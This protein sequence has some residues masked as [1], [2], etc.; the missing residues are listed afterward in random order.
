MHIHIL[1]ICGT[2]MGGLAV[3]AKQAGHKVTGC[4]AN[5]YPPMSTQLEAQG[6]QLIQG[7]GAEQTAL[8]PDLFVIGNVVSRGNPLME[9]ILNRGLPYTS[10]PQWI[11][12]HILADKWVLAVAGTHGKTTTSAMLA[13]I[14]ED[15]G[16]NPGFLIGGV[17]MNFGISAR[18]SGNG[19]ETSASP[20]FVIEADEYDTAFFD[21]RSKFVHYHAKTAILN[22]LE[23]DHADIFPDLAAIET[24][25]HH[26]VRTVPGIGRLVVN[27]REPALQRV[28]T[29]GCWSE[30]ELFGIDSQAAQH[31]PTQLGWSLTTHTDGNFDVIFNGDHQGTVV[32]S[33]TGEHNRMNAIAAIAAA[34][35]VGVP[36]VQAIKAL[37]RFENVKR[38][39]ELR[40][41]VNQIAVYD[42][43]AHHPTA[44]TT[45]IAG[46]RKKIG[47]ARILAVLE[48]RSNT[49]KLGAM[50][51]TLPE[52][53]IDADLVF[54]YGAKG[55]GKEALGWDLGQALAP[56][57]NKAQAFD[58]L[59]R[60]IGA[61][62]QA[63]HPGDQIL[64]MSNGGFG[65]VH[66]K[67]LDA[68][69]NPGTHSLPESAPHSGNASA[70][71]SVIIPARS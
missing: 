66:Q 57:G 61:V 16:Y 34:R 27:A 26:L 38:R 59:D 52:S 9:E 8:T 71:A 69:A 49:M 44:I 29:R 15:A 28:L 17:P 62:A 50:K 6:I 30:Q 64:V 48:P 18:L 42:D 46:L 63:A 11:G 35:H 7:F 39:M 41:I 2:F 12:E 54:G 56:L 43:F 23:Y 40:G 25:F 53:L 31:N 19:I 60:L 68:L 67:I 51:E 70:T 10:G 20:F 58:V 24:Q 13:W 33:L 14:L 55:D 65:G 32:W 4:D 5:V 21:K 36:T 37:G 22:N 3:L 47:N 45:T 1:G